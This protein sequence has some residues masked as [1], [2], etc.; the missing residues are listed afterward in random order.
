M[1]AISGEYSDDIKANYIQKR[2]EEVQNCIVNVRNTSST[3]IGSASWTF[4][5]TGCDVVSVVITTIPLKNGQ[6]N[7]VRLHNKEMKRIKP[8]P[9][10]ISGK[11][12]PGNPLQTT[13]DQDQ[14]KVRKRHA[15]ISYFLCSP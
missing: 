10:K 7:D 8:P 5:T 15:V 3:V 13:D 11:V 12:N 6:M 4:R 9:Q 2:Q 1:S 14:E